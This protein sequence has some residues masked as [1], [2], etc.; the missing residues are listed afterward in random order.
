MLAGYGICILFADF[1]LI[2]LEKTWVFGLKKSWTLT[3]EIAYLLGLFIISSLMI[4]LY[5]L[6]ITKQTAITWDYFAT[7]SY[8]FTVPFA[9]LLLPF[10]AYLRIK[11]GKVISQQQL[12]NPNISLSGQNKEDH[13]EISLQQLLCLKAE[14]NY[15]RIIYLNKNIE[16]QEVL[17]RNTLAAMARQVPQLS[18]CHRSYLVA[19]WHIREL[20]GHKQKAHIMLEQYPKEIPVSSA[21]YLAIQKK[22][23]AKFHP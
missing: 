8:R 15:V 11:Y 12:I 1:I 13:L 16:V 4:Y 6:L 19:H 2:T 17:M 23:S 7:Y 9:L 21:H 20:T 22:M 14:D 3:T 18:Y 10:I 5:D